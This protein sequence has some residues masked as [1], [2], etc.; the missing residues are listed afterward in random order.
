[1]PKLTKREKILIFVVGIVL[2]SYVTVQFGVTP[3]FDR[4]DTGR[5]ELALLTAERNAYE[6]SLAREASLREGNESARRDYADLKETYPAFTANEH[7]DFMLTNLC[8]RHTLRPISLRIQEPANVAAVTITRPAQETEETDEWGTA[9]SAESANS[10]EASVEAFVFTKV[11]AAMTLNGTYSS[12]GDLITTVE[13]MAHIRIT[14]F[15]FSPQG[16]GDRSTPNIAV[17]FEVT[18]FNDVL[19]D[20]L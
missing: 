11:R 19:K 8:V 4:L 2:M 16:G 17:T 10:G 3:L 9:E 13:S 14:T 18:L 20:L 12:L 7:I 5:E 1:M 15:Q 6:A